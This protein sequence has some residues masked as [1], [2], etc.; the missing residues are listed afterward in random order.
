MISV[1]EIEELHRILIDKFGGTHGMRDASALES[2]LAR[3]FQTFDQ[4]E[5]YPTAI[6][7]A[8]SLIESIIANHPFIDGNKRTGYTLMRLFLIS[9]GL[10]I[11]A[12]QADKYNFVMGIASGATEY[13]Q[14]LDWLKAHTQRKSDS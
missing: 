8:A 11:F 3:P 10:D 13:D 1:R 14:I 6:Q 9:N 7:K 5:L 12:S 4:N 2:A